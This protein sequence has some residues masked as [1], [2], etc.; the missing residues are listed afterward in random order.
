MRGILGVG[1]QFIA[2]YLQ[3]VPQVAAGCAD[4]VVATGD[5]AAA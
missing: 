3:A 2:D 5:M 4:H 1:D